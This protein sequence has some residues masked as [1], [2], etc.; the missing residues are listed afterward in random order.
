MAAKKPTKKPNSR[1]KQKKNYLTPDLVNK[2]SDVFNQGI[3][4]NRDWDPE[5]V[6]SETLAMWDKVLPDLHKQCVAKVV[7]EADEKFRVMFDGPA[8]S[9]IN[10]VNAVIDGYRRQSDVG[11]SRARRD[12]MH[13]WH[14]IAYGEERKFDIP[15]LRHMVLGEKFASVVEKGERYIF[16]GFMN[17]ALLNYAS[18]MNCKGQDTIVAFKG[19]LERLLAHDFEKDP[20]SKLPVEKQRK[21]FV[22]S[23][24]KGRP[25][26]TSLFVPKPFEKWVDKSGQTWKG[27][28]GQKYPTPA[29]VEAENLWKKSVM[30][31]V[32]QPV[33]SLKDVEDLLSEDA[34][35]KL[36]ALRDKRIPSS[37]VMKNPDE[38][39]LHAI[40][41]DKIEG[42]IAEQ[43]IRVGTNNT[44][45]YYVPMK[46]FISV[47]EKT[48]FKN[49]VLRYAVWSHE[50]THSTKHLLGRRAA[51]TF[52][53]IPYAK[54]ELVAE[55]CAT[56]QVRNLEEEMTKL[57][58]GELPEVWQGY[59][60][61][62]Y[63]NAVTYSQGWGGKFGFN[64]LFDQL[65]E[66]DKKDQKAGHLRNLMSDVMDA[67]QLIQ[68]G[69]H[70]DQ[71]ITPEKRQQALQDNFEKLRSEKRK[72]NEPEPQL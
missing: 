63:E 66:A 28:E 59:F 56:L 15:W 36:Q 22:L 54:E 10:D 29:Q 33:W 62:Y 9:W 17:Q 18:E 67:F 51:S 44:S 46:D 11:L 5:Q 24:M 72:N 6:K 16:K 30:N 23:K 60:Q 32:S 37:E 42:Q 41:E 52:G 7:N 40:I 68:T 71:A 69:L 19:E 55:T 2:V 50:L 25:S 21:S 39:D 12:I 45:A 58:G 38:P 13:M 34:K 70:K 48:Q 27:P 31:F 65:L 3:L 61:D 20:E 1:A 4:G 53:T 8:A 26:M 47:P 64:V 57:R 49:P 35:E 43:Q 14:E